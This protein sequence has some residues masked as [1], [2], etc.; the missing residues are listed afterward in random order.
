M[1]VTFTCNGQ[2]VNGLTFNDVFDLSAQSCKN[3]ILYYSP[4]HC[5]SY[6]LMYADWC[7]SITSCTAGQTYRPRPL[8]TALDVVQSQSGLVLSCVLCTKLHC[9]INTERS[10]LVQEVKLDWQNCPVLFS[11]L[12]VKI[13]SS[14]GQRMTYFEYS[15]SCGFELHLKQ[16]HCLICSSIKC[17]FGLNQSCT[18]SSAA[19]IQLN[20]Y[21][22]LV[23]E[24]LLQHN[25]QLIVSWPN[26]YVLHVRDGSFR[27]FVMP[28]IPRTQL[29]VLERCSTDTALFHAQ[30]SS[31]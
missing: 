13:S 1:F 7:A 22:L 28:Q 5:S 30:Y 3:L 12:V 21:F 4:S 2:K 29:P 11:N 31:I 20:S 15:Y 8:C 19:I 18:K 10:S 14:V 9:F 23:H 24:L 17:P 26:Y 6:H 25:L 27:I 16:C